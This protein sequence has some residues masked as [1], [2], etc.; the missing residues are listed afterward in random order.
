MGLVQRHFSISGSEGESCDHG[1]QVTFLPFMF[2]GCDWLV[3]VVTHGYGYSMNM[4]ISIGYSTIGIRCVTGRC[5]PSRHL[6]F[7]HFVQK[8]LTPTLD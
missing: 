6:Y 7:L 3:F 4:S 5:L 8:R 1:F 2:D